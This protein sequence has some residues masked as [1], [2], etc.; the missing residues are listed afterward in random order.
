MSA[1]VLGR[2]RRRTRSLRSSRRVVGRGA[3][4]RRPSSAGAAHRSASAHA[5]PRARLGLPSFPAHQATSRSA[6]DGTPRFPGPLLGGSDQNGPKAPP[7]GGC[8][9]ILESCAREPACGA[10]RPREWERGGGARGARRYRSESTCDVSRVS[11]PADF[12]R[13]RGWDSVAWQENGSGVLK[14]LAFTSSVT[15]TMLFP[16]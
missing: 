14:S 7:R 4:S 2:W 13:P 8:K 1:S 11:P 5:A 15:L 10:L 6:H 9:K 12:P 3:Q 16:F